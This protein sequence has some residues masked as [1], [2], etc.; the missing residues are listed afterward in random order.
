MNAVIS[1][2]ALAIGRG[3]S[4]SRSARTSPEASSTSSQLPAGSA[5]GGFGAAALGA[6]PASSA[7]QATS[8][9]RATFSGAA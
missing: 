8:A 9:P 4:G 7:A 5:S 2:V 1:F 6:A 3:V